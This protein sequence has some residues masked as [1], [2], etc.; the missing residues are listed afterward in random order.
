MGPEAEEDW[1]GDETKGVGKFSV[2][3]QPLSRSMSSRVFET[4]LCSWSRANRALERKPSTILLDILQ[5]WPQ[6]RAPSR[7]NTP[8]V[9][10]TEKAR[11]SFVFRLLFLAADAPCFCCVFFVHM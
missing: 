11:P 2:S 10:E 3:I 7:Q 9:R 1:S 4:V 6:E 8:L 5:K